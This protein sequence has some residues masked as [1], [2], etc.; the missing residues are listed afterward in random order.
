MEVDPESEEAQAFL[1]SP[2]IPLTQSLSSK[3]QTIPQSSV[4]LT[5]SECCWF[6]V[7]SDLGL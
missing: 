3:M 4:F 1:T 2:Q 5:S 7:L 6:S